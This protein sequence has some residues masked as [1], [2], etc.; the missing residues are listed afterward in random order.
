MS[1]SLSQ[2]E[3]LIFKNYKETLPRQALSKETRMGV[4]ANGQTSVHPTHQT[5]LKTYCAPYCVPYC[6]QV[7]LRKYYPGDFML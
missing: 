5:A 3:I 6:V 4:P 2:D 7:S 1:V